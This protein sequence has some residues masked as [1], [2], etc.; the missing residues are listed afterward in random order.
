MLDNDDDLYLLLK[1][2]YAHEGTSAEDFLTS[3][4][5]V[6]E[7]LKSKKYLRT[8][9]DA[10]NELERIPVHVNCGV[11]N[12]RTGLKIR[13]DDNLHVHT[14]LDDM[15]G[16]M[17]YVMDHL[18]E[19]HPE[20]IRRSSIQKPVCGL[21][22][23]PDIANPRETLIRYLNLKESSDYDVAGSVF[24]ATGSNVLNPFS[25]FGPY[26]LGGI[27]YS[28][29]TLGLRDY[30]LL[31]KD[32]LEAN[33]IRRKVKNDPI[34]S[35]IMQHLGVHLHVLTV[36][37]VEAEGINSYVSTVEPDLRKMIHQ[38]IKDFPK[39]HKSVLNRRIREPSVLALLD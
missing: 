15:A 14:I 24:L 4:D 2:V 32:V 20:R 11:L 8:A 35:T 18:P 16:L 28:I 7:P 30:Y 25:S 9:L 17:R 10:D 12:Y 13:I 26:K 39:D 38:S 21:I 19:N 34:M 23:A 29:V 36:P 37:E 3:I 5:T 31:G 27:C 33:N 1:N 6:K 22:C